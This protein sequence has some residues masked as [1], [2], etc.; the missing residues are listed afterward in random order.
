[1]RDYTVAVP[2]D[3]VASQTPQRTRRSTSHFEEV[4]KLRTPPASRLRLT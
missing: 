2:R 4:M 1:M 3:C